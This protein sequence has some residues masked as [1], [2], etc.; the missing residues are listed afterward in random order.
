[1]CVCVCM[2]VWVFSAF[3]CS[4]QK[5]TYGGFF[6]IWMYIAEKHSGENYGVFSAVFLLFVTIWNFKN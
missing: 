2:K 6:S 1:M 5:N 4:S 3:Y